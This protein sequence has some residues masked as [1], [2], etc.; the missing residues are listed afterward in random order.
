MIKTQI[1]IRNQTRHQRTTYLSCYET[2]YKPVSI[3]KHIEKWI[4]RASQQ[5]QHR[6]NR[7]KI[8]K[9]CRHYQKSQ[10]AHPQT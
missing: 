4:R 2:R 5:K 10:P 3:Y 1:R 7:K 8:R 9:T 6:R